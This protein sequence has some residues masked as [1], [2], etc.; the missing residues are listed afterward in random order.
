MMSDD[1][2]R[3]SG[4]P[5]PVPSE[6]QQLSYVTQRSL[7]VSGSGKRRGRPETLRLRHLCLGGVLCGL[8]GFGSQRKRWRRLC[9]EPVGAFARCWWEIR[10]STT[11]S[12]VEEQER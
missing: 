9:L 12:P 4:K 8:E 11:G 3:K 2:A 1:S 7:A 6:Q 5:L 10:R